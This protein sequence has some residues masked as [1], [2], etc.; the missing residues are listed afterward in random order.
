MNMIA[1]PSQPP[2]STAAASSGASRTAS[3]DPFNIFQAHMQSKE[4]EETP[5]VECVDQILTEWMIAYA[6]F[7]HSA[8]VLVDDDD[9]EGPRGPA[10]QEKWTN[11]FRCWIALGQ[12]TEPGLANDLQN[13]QTKT[14][15]HWDEAARCLEKYLET[16]GEESLPLRGSPITFSQLLGIFCSMAKQVL[17]RRLIQGYRHECIQALVAFNSQCHDLGAKAICYLSQDTTGEANGVTISLTGADPWMK[18]TDSR[19]GTERQLAEGVLGSQA[20]RSTDIGTIVPRI[21]TKRAL[22]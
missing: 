18:Y 11:C 4:Q 1:E 15:A 3:K 19:K 13:Q 9:D 7:Q 2:P 17:T 22:K 21:Q 6:H 16:E 10:Q 8:Q 5:D 14:G 12:Q 20:R